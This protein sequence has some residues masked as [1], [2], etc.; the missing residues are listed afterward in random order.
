MDGM[1]LLTMTKSRYVDDLP[2]GVDENHPLIQTLSG[3]CSFHTASD[4]ASFLFSNQLQAMMD[5]DPWIVFEMGVY[6]DHTKTVEVIPVR[7]SITIAD[8]HFTG[9]FKDNVGSFSDE[10]GLANAL[11]Q[12]HDLVY[13]DSGR[14]A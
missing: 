14:F 7:G 5:D 4:L 8:T 6:K 11:Q 12:W 10:E 3:L 13:T 9:A 1:P 2:E